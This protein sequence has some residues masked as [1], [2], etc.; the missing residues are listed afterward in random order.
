MTSLCNTAHCAWTSDPFNNLIILV[1]HWGC[2]KQEQSSDG[3]SRPTSGGFITMNS[4]QEEAIAISMCVI[5]FQ[6]Q[7]ASEFSGN[8]GN[9][10]ANILC[11]TSHIPRPTPAVIP[12]TFSVMI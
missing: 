8:F 2:V 3:L 11:V 7:P 12:R 6:E 4:G 9:N 5:E 10:A 1:E